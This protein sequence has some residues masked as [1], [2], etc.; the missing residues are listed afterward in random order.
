MDKSMR[1]QGARSSSW[2]YE[3]FAWGAVA[4][5]VDIYEGALLTGS[6]KRKLA[7]LLLSASESDSDAQ[8]ALAR[9]RRGAAARYAP[10][11][12]PARRVAGRANSDLSDR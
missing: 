7:F 12:G 11:H 10:G 8:D 5:N 2:S 1:H 3:S 4:G 9:G 6:V